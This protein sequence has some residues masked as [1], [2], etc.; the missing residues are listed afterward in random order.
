MAWAFLRRGSH[1][2]T[3]HE[4][5]F[6]LPFFPIRF[7]TWKGCPT[8][9]P[10]NEERLKGR[11]VIISPKGR[12]KSFTRLWKYLGVHSVR[13]FH[14]TI[15]Y[16]MIT[17]SRKIKT[18]VIWLCEILISFSEIG[19]F[20]VNSNIV[21]RRE[22]EV[23]WIVEGLERYVAIFSCLFIS[24]CSNVQFD[25]SLSR[26]WVTSVESATR[27][28]HPR[29]AANDQ[30]SILPT[31]VNVTLSRC[32]ITRNL[33]E[34]KKIRSSFKRSIFV[35]IVSKAVLKIAVS[36]KLIVVN[37]RLTLRWL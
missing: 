35:K 21:K 32:T 34:K 4:I 28:Q 27:Q 8:R 7:S 5:S 31:V 19:G 10:R 15:I 11:V 37:I 1:L 17:F 18:I 26:G 16:M 22:E 24:E 23:C 20:S 12:G 14:N 3:V 36:S 30:R 6:H 9:F 13:M 2:I 25:G 33:F 29:A